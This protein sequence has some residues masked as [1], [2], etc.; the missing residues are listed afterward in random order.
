M[1]MPIEQVPGNASRNASGNAS[2][3]SAKSEADA[4]FLLL[5]AQGDKQA[6]HMLFD[7]YKARVYRYALRL[8]NNSAVAEDVVSEVFL[9]VWR[10][11]ARFE[12]RSK[13]STW[14]LA[15]A[16]NL[17]ATLLSRRPLE[18]LDQ[19]VADSIPDLADDPEVTIAKLQEKKEIAACLRKLSPPHREIIDLIYYHDK[20][21][22]EAAEIIGVPKSTVKT[23]MFY[24]RNAIAHLLEQR[25]I[26]RASHKVN[27]RAPCLA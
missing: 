25:G 14:L 27:S 17:A 22:A 12:G 20:T 5:I 13:V 2:W 15:I 24:A 9:T 16:G 23:R 3:N 18:G 8:T 4:S 11:S 6:M 26:N 1:G 10:Q 19:G 21:V 7:R